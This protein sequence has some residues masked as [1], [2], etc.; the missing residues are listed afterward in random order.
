MSRMPL[1]SFLP[2][3]ALLDP[4]EHPVTFP[5][6]VPSHQGSVI[7]PLA[8]PRNANQQVSY[9]DDRQSLAGRHLSTHSAQAQL[10]SQYLSP[11]RSP[12]TA[13]ASNLISPTLSP[14]TD[15]GEHTASTQL[16]RVLIQNRRLLENWEAERAH[17]EANRSR[18]EEIYKEERAIMDEDRLIWAEKEAQYL[19][20]I[21]D[22]ERENIALRESITRNTREKSRDSTARS[23]LGLGLE[24]SERPGVKFRSLQDST[25]PIATPVI[26]LGHTMPESRPFVPLDPR[27]QGSSTQTST[28]GD[29]PETKENNI[30]S[31][32]VQE[33]HP[34]LEGIPLRSTAVKKSTFTDG[35]PPSPPLSG[36]NVTG[37]N[38]NSNAGSPGSG[39]RSK[40]TPAEV[41]QETL[42]APE[43]SR[44]TMHAGHTPNH[45]LSTFATALSTNATNTAGSSGASTPTHGQS[46]GGVGNGAAYTDGQ[47]DHAAEDPKP[48]LEPSE[49][50]PEL[51]GPLSLRNQQAFDEIFLGKVADKL[52]DS[53]QT[54]DATPTVL[55][56]GADEPEVVQPVPAALDEDD[57]PLKPEASEDVPLK[58]KSNSNFGA[59]LGTLQGF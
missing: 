13:G 25:S 20:R 15:S 42:Q 56:H 48:L 31:I 22:L 18:A 17:L 50:D 39:S 8:L 11:L 14:L 23:P 2:S 46:H 40:A 55:K 9:F 37:S 10:Q 54:D 52:L 44:L 24:H 30:P 3:G 32:D 6:L 45:S 38:P 29:G 19:A 28:P 7:S 58:F 27:M 34:D 53:I 1:D 12:P 33:V 5:G 26:G 57:E 16:R 51:R 36:S 4:N 59:P 21:T 41:T 47:Q 43:A 49:R 35:K